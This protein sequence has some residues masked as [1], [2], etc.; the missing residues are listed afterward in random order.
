M[1]V[2]RS[3]SRCATRNYAPASFSNPPRRDW[4]TRKD[5][6]HAVKLTKKRLCGSNPA[7][8]IA[9]CVTGTGSRSSFRWRKTRRLLQETVESRRRN[10]PAE[11]ARSLRE[12]GAGSQPSLW[13]ELGG[14]SVPAMVVA[15]GLDEKF[16]GIGRRMEAEGP[17]VDFVS[18]PDVGHNVH[19]EAPDAY[20][21]L[22]QGFLESI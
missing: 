14:L 3:T 5:G 13:D 1:D 9:S 4:K 7:I 8:S 15:G 16:V 21:G 20:I 10:E 18:V 19:S 6:P 2:S 17:M 11:L 12:M 22:L